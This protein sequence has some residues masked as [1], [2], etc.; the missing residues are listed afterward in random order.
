MGV[1]FDDI[2]MVESPSYIHHTWKSQDP[3][4]ILIISCSDSTNQ[5]KSKE[6]PTVSD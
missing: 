2:C 5:K 4:H 6:V 1:Q 3:C